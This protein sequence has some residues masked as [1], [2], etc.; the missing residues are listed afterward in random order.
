MCSFYTSHLL[1]KLELCTPFMCYLYYPLF[2]FYCRLSIN[3]MERHKV[4]STQKGTSMSSLLTLN[5]T[6]RLAILLKDGETPVPI[7]RPSIT[8]SNN[9]KTLIR[10]YSSLPHRMIP[11]SSTPLTEWWEGMAL[12]C[13]GMTLARTQQSNAATTQQTI[14]LDCSS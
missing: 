10:L 4:V 11:I 8:L 9:F 1:R 14:P 5:M 7:A 13:V 12:H 2:P 6:I 3:V